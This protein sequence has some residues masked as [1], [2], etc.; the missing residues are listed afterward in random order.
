LR[1]HSLVGVYLECKGKKT[2]SELKLL[3]LLYVQKRIV[4]SII[5]DLL[6]TKKNMSKS[7]IMVAIV[8]NLQT[9]KL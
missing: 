3:Q 4:G 1:V 8:I 2:V 7:K 5:D 6:L 9:L